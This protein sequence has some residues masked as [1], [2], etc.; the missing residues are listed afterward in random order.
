MDTYIQRV[1]I[2]AGNR[3][4][5]RDFIKTTPDKKR[6]F[7]AGSLEAL[8][9]HFCGNVQTIGTFWQRRDAGKLYSFVPTLIKMTQNYYQK[10]YS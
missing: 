1:L 5:Y 4:E 9:G 8:L 7:Y 10:Y 6:Y 2:L 3:R